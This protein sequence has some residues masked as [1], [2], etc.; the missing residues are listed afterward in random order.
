MATITC[1]TC[2]FTV[3][4]TAKFCSNCGNAIPTAKYCHQCGFPLQEG[5]E[6]CQGCGQNVSSM[7]Q[8]TN[9]SFE[10]AQNKWEQ[11][12]DR[13]LLEAYKI[14]GSYS[15]EVKFAIIEAYN[16]RLAH[17]EEYN[18]RLAHGDT[19]INQKLQ[20]VGT[21]GS[22]IL[23]VGV[24]APLVSAPIAGSIN[25]IQNGKGDGTIILLLAVLSFILT[26]QKKYI[27]LW[28][29][30]IGSL[31]VTLF[32]FINLQIRMSEINHKLEGKMFAGLANVQFQWG[33]AL[34][35]LG[36]VLLIYCAEISKKQ[37]YL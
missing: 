30:G 21:I 16:R 9:P 29:T 22:A 32:T 33:W 31:A 28:V 19:S 6:F 11:L 18:R 12:S 4:S 15:K 8:Q 3:D 27:G 34:L 10:I 14:C 2:N 36:A 23:L 13:E 1:T 35:I 24:F 25:Y 20:L 37:H 7:Q 17:I 26:L 5:N